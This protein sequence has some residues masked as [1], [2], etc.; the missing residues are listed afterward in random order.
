MKTTLKFLD[1]LTESQKKNHKHKI[2]KY[3]RCSKENGIANTRETP[4]Y[5]LKGVEGFVEVA[6]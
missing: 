5:L 3:F 1:R 4:L 6:T 2:I